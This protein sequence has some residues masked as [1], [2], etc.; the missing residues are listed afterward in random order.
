MTLWLDAIPNV[1]RARAAAALKEGDWLGFLCTASNHDGL[2]LVYMNVAALKQHGVYEPALLAAL[3]ASRVKNRHMDI[4]PW[5]I[6]FARQTA[7]S[8]G[9]LGSPLP[10]AA[11]FTVYRGVAYNTDLEERKRA[12]EALRTLDPARARWFPARWDLPKLAVWSGRILESD[13]LAYV[14]GRR[15]QEIIALPDTVQN[16]RQTRSSD[17][18]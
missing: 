4:A 2:W 3:T 11:P 18:V 8:C 16:L 5:C 12:E 1:L 14:N 13:V 10:A 15:E 9:L 7:R 17:I 6:S